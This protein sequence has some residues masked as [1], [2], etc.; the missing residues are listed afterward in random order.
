M[1][2]PGQRS[3]QISG[4]K[5]SKPT[6][7]RLPKLPATPEPADLQEQSSIYLSERNRWTNLVSFPSN[8][9]YLSLFSYPVMEEFGQPARFRHSAKGPVKLGPAPHQ[10]GL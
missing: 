5:G 8:L 7:R 1:P 4:A 9:R 2:L 10:V 6:R 3:D